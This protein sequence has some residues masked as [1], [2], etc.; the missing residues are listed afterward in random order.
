MWTCAKC[1]ERVEDGFEVCWSCGTTIDGVEDPN[2]FS[3]EA[4]DA[5]APP[6]GD[7]PEHLI[8]VTSCSKP[9]EALALRLKLEAAGIAV[10]LADEYTIAMDWLLSNAIGGIK[11]QV[12]E[13]DVP[14][15]C[16]TLGIEL[17]VQ[18]EEEQAAD[19]EDTDAWDEE[20]AEDDDTADERV[21]EE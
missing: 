21:E 4:E 16:E 20:D 6:A 15:A 3:A 1:G 12:S 10:F 8:T 13:T 5:P 2:F 11:V 19:E 17:P 18:P 14:R 7:V 9:A